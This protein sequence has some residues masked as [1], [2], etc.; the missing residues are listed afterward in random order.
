MDGFVCMQAPAPAS[1]EKGPITPK[2]GM[3]KVIDHGNAGA[4]STVPMANAPIS[5]MI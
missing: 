3:V 5:Q 1:Q 2:G 4:T